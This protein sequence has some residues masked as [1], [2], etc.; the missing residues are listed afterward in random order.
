MFTRFTKNIREYYIQWYDHKVV[1]VIQCHIFI[2]SRYNN[3]DDID[4]NLSH[5]KLLT[6]FRK[7]KTILKQK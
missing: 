1:G 4:I 3:W 7:R 6:S 5:T 2:V